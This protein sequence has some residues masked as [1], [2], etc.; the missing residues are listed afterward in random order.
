MALTIQQQLR[1]QQYMQPWTNSEF[2]WGK[3]DC[4]QFFIGWHDAVYG[5]NDLPRVQNQ[6]TSRGTARQFLR[7]LGLTSRQWLTMRGY[8]QLDS[9]DFEP[10]DVVLHDFKYHSS[11]FIYWEGVFVSSVEGLNFCAFAPEAMTVGNYTA[12]RK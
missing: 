2:Q 8:K 11:V 7:N 1:G 10:G 3:T 6:Y 12:W 4:N 9:T 5:S